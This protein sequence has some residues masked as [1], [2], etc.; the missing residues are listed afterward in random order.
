MV[1]PTNCQ[2]LRAQLKK[3]FAKISSDNRNKS[4][5]K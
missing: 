1:G 3:K 4:I 5:I 2:T